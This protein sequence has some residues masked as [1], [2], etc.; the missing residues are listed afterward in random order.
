MSKY[1]MYFDIDAIARTQRMYVNLASG[2]F[3][4]TRFRSI[5]F[6]ACSLVVIAWVARSLTLVVSGGVICI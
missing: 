4:L 2:S 1:G 5:Y 3:V 6:V